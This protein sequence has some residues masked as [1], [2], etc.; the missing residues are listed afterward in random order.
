MSHKVR[1]TF[2][3]KQQVA[4]ISD[5]I[6]QDSRTNAQH[7]R[8]SIRERMRSLK[9]FPERH[10]V[11]YLARDV[12]RDIRHT[13]Y[14]VYRILYTIEGDTVVVLTVRHGAAGR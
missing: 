13:F 12:G 2:E 14:G 9:D 1:L 6:A 5:Y 7:W 10:E 11:A 8:Q 3:V 4:V